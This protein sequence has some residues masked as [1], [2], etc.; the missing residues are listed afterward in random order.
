MHKLYLLLTS[1]T[2]GYS[3]F[4]Q[5]TTNTGGGSGQANNIIF[6]WSIGELTLVNTAQNG[7]LMFT[8]GVLQGKLVAFTVTGGISN[9]E[10][11]VTPNPTTG[12]L[13]IQAGFLE[14]GQLSMSLYDAQGKLL[15]RTNETISSFGSRTMNLIPF[16]SGL[17]LLHAE[18]KPNTGK[19]RKQTYKILKF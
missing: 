7:N 11:F 5:Q 8:N 1:L 15:I 9:G 18:F 13:N 3:S 17:Y 16:A 12:I 19:A 2:L 14:P 6:D 4:A 10:L